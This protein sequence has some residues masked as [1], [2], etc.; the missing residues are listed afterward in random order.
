MPPRWPL[1]DRFVSIYSGLDGRRTWEICPVEWDQAVPGDSLTSYYVLLLS[2][3]MGCRARARILCSGRESLGRSWRNM[4]RPFLEHLQQKLQSSFDLQP[5]TIP[6]GLDYRANERGRQPTTIQSWCYTCPELRKIRYT[7]IDGGENAQVFNSVIYPSH[8]YELPL[9]GVDLLSFGKKKNLIVLDFQPLFRDE[10][11]LARYI[12]PMRILRERYSDVAQDVEMKFYDANQYFSKY[13]LFARTDAETI[14]GRMFAAYC[15]YLDLYWQ[16]LAAAV[17]W[18]IRRMSGASSRPKKITTSTAPIATRPRD[19][20]A[21]TLATSGPSG[22]CTNFCSKMPCRWRWASPG[23][24]PLRTLSRRCPG[25]AH[26]AAGTGTL[27][28]CGGF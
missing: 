2:F 27:P 13:L 15:D 25:A 26:P 18:T 9:L 21:A 1:L 19:C 28:D 16:L 4:Y 20:S 23:D 24:D 7:Y 22:F 14:E 12:E 10:A 5:L 17:P 8:G 11:Y 6:A 3:A